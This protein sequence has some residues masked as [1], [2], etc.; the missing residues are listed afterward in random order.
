MHQRCKIAGK[1]RGSEDDVITQQELHDSI[2]TVPV[3][4]S[5]PC[6]VLNRSDTGRYGDLMDKEVHNANLGHTVPSTMVRTRFL[7]P[8]FLVPNTQK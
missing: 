2:Q 1:F 3:A 4:G 5:L 7:L 8:D 6:V